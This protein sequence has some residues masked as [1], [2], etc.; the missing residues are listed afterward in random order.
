MHTFLNAASTLYFLARTKRTKNSK[1]FGQ[2]KLT[3]AGKKHRDRLIKNETFLSLRI[4]EQI[5]IYILNLPVV[6]EFLAH[7]TLLD[8]PR[9]SDP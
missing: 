1:S 4:L 3:S 2:F 9:Q 5:Y 7:K 6:Y 8:L